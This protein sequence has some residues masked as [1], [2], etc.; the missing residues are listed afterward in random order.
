MS[1]SARFTNGQGPINEGTENTDI[2]RNN[3]FLTPAFAATIALAVYA[4]YTLVQPAVLTGVVTFSVNVGSASTGP[5]VG[6]KIDFLLTPDGTSR[7]V[8]FGTGFA[9]NGTISVTTAKFASISFMFNGTSWI[10]T[11]RT[12]T[13]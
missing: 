4:S 8:T 3:Q 12:V 11:G 7:V 2:L 5:Y 1:T 9:P 13:A 10:E 6:D